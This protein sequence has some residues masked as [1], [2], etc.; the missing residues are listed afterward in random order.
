[1]ARVQE[2]TKGR[3]IVSII[4]SSLDALAESLKALERKFGPVQ[5]ETLEIDCNKTEMYT[6]EMGSE[7]LRRFFS[8]ERLA[9]R[10]WLVEMKKI[11]HKIEP[12]FADQTA[13]YDF[14]TVN[15]DPGILTPSNLTMASHR[16][17]NHRVYLKDGVYAE[18]ALIYARG[19]FRRLPW[20][21]PDY[22]QGEAIEFFMRVHESFE[23]AES[24]VG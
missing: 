22:C 19:Q 12:N 5:Y 18:L 20:T 14:R 24:A 21:N 17:L 3:P 9:E 4:Y 13:G 11:C 15:I 2:P 1:M 6:E 16:E 7:L 8:F 23:L 10:G